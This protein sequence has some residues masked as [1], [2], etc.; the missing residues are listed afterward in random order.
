MI[1]LE[2]KISTNNIP[3]IG[4]LSKQ[5]LKKVLILINVIYPMLLI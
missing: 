4:I 3:L 5:V 1:T 2:G